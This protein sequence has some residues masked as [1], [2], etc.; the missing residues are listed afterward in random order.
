MFVCSCTVQKWS[1]LS[2]VS[3]DLGQGS[4]KEAET[5]FSGIFTTALLTCAAAVGLTVQFC[6]H[7]KKNMSRGLEW[8]QAPCG[9]L[10]GLNSAPDLMV[11]IAVRPFCEPWFLYV[12][13]SSDI[14]VRHTAQTCLQA[15]LGSSF[16]KCNLLLFF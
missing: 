13:P 2:S 7:Y 16:W 11:P 3:G 12:V 5:S 9:F 10:K 8:S 6:E 14:G 15:Q 1:E 4:L